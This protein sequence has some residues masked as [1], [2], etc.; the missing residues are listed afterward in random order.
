MTVGASD[1]P[2]GVLAILRSTIRNLPPETRKGIRYVLV[3]YVAVLALQV[4]DSRDSH[5]AP[6]AA[7]FASVLLGT[8]GFMLMGFTQLLRGVAEP[9]ARLPGLRLAARADAPPTATTRQIL[10]ALPLVGAAAAV[11]L[12][13]AIAFL[14]T[15]LWLGASA[16][17]LVIG[18]VYLLA[19]AAA[20]QAVKD[21]ASRLY[22]HAQDE[23]ARAGQMTA[24]LTQA[25]LT[26]LQS[27]MNPHFLFNAL[28]T[29]ASLT[30]SN[31][32][33]AE[34]TVV[35]LSEV[36]RATLDRSEQ[37]KTTLENEL[38]FVR[39]YLSVEL[40]RFGSRLK[41]EYDV[42]PGLELAVV[43]SFSLQPLVENALKHGPGTRLEG[44]S[45]RV[46]AHRAAEAVRLAVD[47]DGD[48]FGSTY[49]EGTGLGNLRERLM[50]MYGASADLAVVPRVRGCEVVITLPL[51]IDQERRCAY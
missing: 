3:A 28:N 5:G 17:V 23:A 38:A 24:A 31:P 41:V 42:E 7:E 43:P 33:A 36:L 51:E 12:S 20:L 29:V 9:P 45:I 48:G 13:G 22:A 50:V 26:A 4:W 16:I 46:T 19:L 25:R 2:P 18:V 44:G 21:A 30:R 39:A 14:V 10:L 27:Q 47:D 8:G 49:T 40:A 32:S 6:G 1:P 37:R 11:M 15:R 35:N 34:Q